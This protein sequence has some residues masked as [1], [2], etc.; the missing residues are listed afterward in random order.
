MGPYKTEREA[1]KM[2]DKWGRLNQRL[3][4]AEQPLQF[5]DMKTVPADVRVYITEC[6][7]A[8]SKHLDR[9]D[10]GVVFGKNMQ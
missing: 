6:L 4:D 3:M 8:M 1:K 2:V 7:T 10:V 5:V 9:D